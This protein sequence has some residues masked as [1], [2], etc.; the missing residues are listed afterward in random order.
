M[1][2]ESNSIYP[3][4]GHLAIAAISHAPGPDASPGVDYTITL[5]DGRQA[6]IA[7]DTDAHQQ[8]TRILLAAFEP[9]VPGCSC[10]MADYGAPGHDGAG[11]DGAGL[12]G[13]A[14]AGS[15]ATGG[16]YRASF[17]AQAWVRDYAMDVDPQGETSWVVSDEY[18]ASAARIVADDPVDG[19]DTD[20]VL[21]SDP[22]APAWVREWAGPFSIHVTANG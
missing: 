18:T 14:P 12:E 15:D 7:E 13:A 6:V 17:T 4:V 5:P 20:D 1:S 9:D 8:L 19:L 16:R 11:E 21:K 3:G 22:A 10:G 2:S